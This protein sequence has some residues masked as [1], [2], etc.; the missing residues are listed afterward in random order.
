MYVVVEWV[1]RSPA[2][3]RALSSAPAPLLENCPRRFGHYLALDQRCPEHPPENAP[4]LLFAFPDP[5]SPPLALENPRRRLLEEGLDRKAWASAR[6]ASPRPR[7]ADPV[8][9]FPCPEVSRFSGVRS[10]DG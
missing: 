5:A 10:R 4:V 8:A 3:G 1:Q 7:L 9:P 2:P 6:R